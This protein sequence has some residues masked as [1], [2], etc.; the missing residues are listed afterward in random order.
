[1]RE[2]VKLAVQ[3]DSLI[4]VGIVSKSET[5]LKIEGLFSAARATITDE[6]RVS[7]LNLIMSS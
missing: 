6:H 7:S 3:Y 2:Y 4:G 1:M 5:D